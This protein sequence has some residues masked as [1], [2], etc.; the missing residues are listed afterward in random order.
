MNNIIKIVLTGGPCAGKTTAMVRIIE[1]F[2]GLGYQVFSLPEVPT[3]FSTS[4]VNYLTDNKKFFYQAEKAT[5]KLQLEMEDLYYEMAQECN[6]PV[7]IVCDRGTMDISTYLTEDMWMA[8]LNEGGYNEVALR[9]ARY[10]AVLHMVTAAKGAEE[11]YTTANN[12]YRSEGVELARELDDR[13][14]KAW[15]G[16]HHLRIID[17]EVSFEKKLHRVLEEISNVLGTPVPIEQERKYIVE[18]VGEI[19][20]CTESEITQT[21]IQTEEDEEVRIRRRGKQGSYVYFL[22]KKKK[23]SET[24]QIETERKITPRHY[25]ELLHMADPLRETIVKTRKNFVWH[26]QYFELD[27][28]IQPNIGLNILEIEGVKEPENLKFPPFLKV[29]EDVTGKK[30]YYNYNLSV[31]HK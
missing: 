21:Y 18:V 16:H 9:D 20:N 26:G 12:Q 29:I 30:E 1:H 23:V 5:L 25:V 11:F 10:D 17:N 19:P 8:I 28:Y 6:K 24:E 27:S 7:I 31:K 4:G 14:I 2:T 22:T 13:Q 3:M 15:T